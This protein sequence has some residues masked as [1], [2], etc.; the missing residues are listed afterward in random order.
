MKNA[1]GGE[2][3]IDHFYLGDRVEGDRSTSSGFLLTA[4]C[5]LP[6]SFSV[7]LCLCGY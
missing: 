5:L 2:N 4:Y 7:S 6:S 1:V 3:E